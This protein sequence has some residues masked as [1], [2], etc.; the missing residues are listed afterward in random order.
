M[1]ETSGFMLVVVH[2]NLSLRNHIV[3]NF[4]FFMPIKTKVAL[5]VAGGPFKSGHEVGDPIEGDRAV[6]RP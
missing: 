4:V 1:A 3:L 2:Y 5:M 6:G